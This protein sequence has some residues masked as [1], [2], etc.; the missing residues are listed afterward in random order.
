V[1]A[2]VHF[3]YEDVIG[4]AL[5][6]WSTPEI[7]GTLAIA[8]QRLRA[9]EIV[10]L[11]DVIHGSTMSEG[12]ARAVRDA[13]DVLRGIAKL[14]LVAGNHEGRT[15]GEAVLGDTVEYAQ[16]DGWL[17]LHGDRAPFAHARSIIGHLHPSMPLG[18]GESAP[19]FLASET[20]VVVP[21]LTPYS[22]GLNVLSNEC[23][24]A[25]RPWRNS[26][27]ADLNVVAAAGELLYPFGSLTELRALFAQESN[28]GEGVRQPYRMGKYQR[29]PR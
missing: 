7:A 27:N 18:P 16:R 22:R 29:T 14:T 11:G 13:L 8:A 5:P 23:L 28:A 15:R 9:E 4:G 21:A 2:D 6:T 24:R 12:A 10:L 20:L 19:A 17:L 25:L 3:A 1:A 26:P